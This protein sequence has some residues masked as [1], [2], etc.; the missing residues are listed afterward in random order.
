MITYTKSTVFNVKAHTIVNTINCVGVMGAG[1]A[2][3]FKLRF[4]EMYDDYKQHCQNKKVKTGQPYIYIYDSDLMIMNFPTK[5]HWKY[6]SKIEWIEAGLK[7]FV[8]NYEK[9]K[10]KSVAFP[11]L[12]S[13]YGKLN[14]KNVQELMES[15]LSPLDIEIY[16]CLDEENEA[17]GVEKNML[18]MLNRMDVPRL[19][20]QLKMPKN[21]LENILSS[22]PLYRF[23]DLQKIKGVGK[24]NYE[25][26]FKLFYNK[27]QDRT[28]VCDAPLNRPQI[29]TQQLLFD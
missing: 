11:K 9:H 10:I 3:E 29:M 20:S 23:Y 24:K 27:A 28:A 19:A 14:W 21:I 4:P 6:P 17:V 1:L 12:G 18:D 15:Y 16:I 5:L 26:I 7:Y 13:G 25:Y 22:L 2:L 8:S